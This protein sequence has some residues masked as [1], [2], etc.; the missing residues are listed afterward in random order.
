MQ[1]HDAICCPGERGRKRKEGGEAGRCF[2][3]VTPWRRRS[4]IRSI[5]TE[6]CLHEDDQLESRHIEDDASVHRQALAAEEEEGRGLCECVCICLVACVR[7]CI[8]ACASAHLR[9][10]VDGPSEKRHE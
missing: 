4:G 9:M 6:S 7:A 3:F 2:C 8:R 10:R 1:P 5:R